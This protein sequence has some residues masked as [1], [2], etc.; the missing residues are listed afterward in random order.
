[1]AVFA[2]V[3]VGPGVGV[4]A[5]QG[6]LEGL[7][8]DLEVD[9]AFEDGEGAGGEDAG[10]LACVLALGLA[11]FDDECGGSAGL[12]CEQLEE[13]VAAFGGGGRRGLIAARRVVRL[14]RVLGGVEGEGEVDDGDVHG[15]VGED[16]GCFAARMDAEGVDAERFEEAWEAVGPGFVLPVGG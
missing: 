15:V 14:V 1:V 16:L 2:V 8:D 11:A 6:A 12:A 9:G 5:A 13:A 10:E 7:E 3:L 4:V